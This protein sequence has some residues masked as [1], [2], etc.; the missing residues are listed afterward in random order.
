MFRDVGGDGF[1]EVLAGLGLLFFE[2][3][4]EAEAFVGEHLLDFF[5]GGFAEVF[6]AEEFGFGDFEEVAEGADVHFLEAVA[7]ADGEFEIGD[8][9]FEEGIA[10]FGAFFDV[11]V[12]GHGEGRIDIALVELA[13]GVVGVDGEEA[14]EAFLGIVIAFDVLIQDGEV[15]ED[16]FAHG[17]AVGEDFVD[18]DGALV[19]S[20]EIEEVGKLEHDIFVFVIKLVGFV[21]AVDGGLNLAV[22]EGFE[23]L[24]IEL[25]GL[26]NIAGGFLHCGGFGNLSHASNS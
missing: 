3:H 23:G 7:G 14:G 5:E 10:F 17:T 20:A 8:R 2:G 24:I 13:A 16:A 11:F 18:F 6:V 22:G 4:A 12:E 1:E 15:E 9:G 25:F 19:G 21:E 26:C